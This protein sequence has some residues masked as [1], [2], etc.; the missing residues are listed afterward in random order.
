MRPGFIGKQAR[1][2]T[3]VPVKA[4]YNLIIKQEGYCHSSVDLSA[5][6]ILPPRV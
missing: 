1:N 4:I 5:P 3:N 2:D 6:T